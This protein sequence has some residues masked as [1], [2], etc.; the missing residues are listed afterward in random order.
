LSER[1]FQYTIYVQ[2]K[3][4]T[5]DCGYYTVIQE[6]MNTIKDTKCLWLPTNA[7][8]IQMWTIQKYVQ[9]KVHI[10]VYRSVI[11]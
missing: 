5:L 3:Y 4:N 6:N 8:C 2:Y 7:Y 9:N 1:T 10:I 11:S